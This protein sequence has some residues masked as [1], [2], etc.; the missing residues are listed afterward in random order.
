MLDSIELEMLS[1]L[2]VTGYGTR[3]LGS[4]PK[5]GSKFTTLGFLDRC[6]IGVS[7]CAIMVYR[8]QKM[9]GVPTVVPVTGIK[10]TA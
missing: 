4:T 2:A 6:F 10:A 1:H 8:L 3:Y 5:G 7:T 9:R